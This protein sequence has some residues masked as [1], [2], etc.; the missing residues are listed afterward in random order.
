MAEYDAIQYFLGANSP[1]G[2]YSLYDQ[3]LPVEGARQICI[4]KG[5]PGCGK[6]T[7][8]RKVAERLT[9]AGCT[10]E[11][12]L[13]SGD[14]DSLDGVV[15][16]ELGVALVDGT[17]PHV[18]EP[19]YPGVVERYVDLG[20]CY[21]RVGLGDVKSE[22]MACMKGYK[23]C[24]QRAYRCLRAAAE[25]RRDVRATLTTDT[26]RIRLERRAKGI[27]AREC[28]KRKDVPAGAVRQRFLDGV[29]HRGV[30][31]L[32]HT[33]LA[34]CGRIYE[35]ADRFGLANEMLAYLLSGFT[36]NGY[37]VVACPDPMAPERLAHL[38]VPE[39]SLAFLSTTPERELPEV[40][41]RRIRLDAM[42]DERLMRRTR[43]RLRFSRKMVNALI[44]EGVESLAQAKGMHDDLEGL[45]NPYVDFDRVDQMAQEIAGELLGIAGK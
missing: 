34:Q 45:Y 42:A 20:E 29:T 8:M 33:A 30:I 41:C 12:I 32:Y 23:G 35:L 6:S 31:T 9:C 1:S 28:R 39:L 2:F 26:L 22:I 43:P 15:F 44:E 19:K 37:D 5:G 13:C 16:R 25:I 38:L 40:P 4:L 10:G 27:L 24:Y 7:L 36:S 17:A 18:I 11:Y 3:L 21:D 14:P